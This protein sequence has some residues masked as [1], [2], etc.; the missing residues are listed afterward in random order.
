MALSPDLSDYAAKMRW[1]TH[2]GV[3]L[4]VAARFVDMLAP[5]EATILDIGCGIGNTVAALR[6]AGHLAFGIDPNPEVLQVASELFAP[7]WFRQL[8]AEELPSETLEGHQL[9][10]TFDLILMSGNVPA[11]LTEA[12]LLTT[13]AAADELLKTGGR[14]I[15]GT[16]THRRGGPAD[17]DHY[18]ART[19]LR[20]EHRY[21]DWHLG[22]FDADSPWSVSVY[23][24][25]GSRRT[26]EGPDGIHVLPPQLTLPAT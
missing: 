9:P 24:A 13:F 19:S 3:D 2:S 23:S 18:A 26:T 8:S 21:A 11:F 7:T 5:R 6:S 10:K 15:V 20:L 16:T 12:E 22:T 4:E 14:L 1:L 17:L 25:H